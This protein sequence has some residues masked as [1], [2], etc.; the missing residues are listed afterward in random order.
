MSRKYSLCLAVALASVALDQITKYEIREHIR[1]Q[2]EEIPIF[3][4]GVVSASL[5]HAQNKGA[6]FGVLENQTAFFIGFTILAVGLLLYMLRELPSNDRFQATAIGLILSGALGNLIDRLLQGSV[7]DFIR[8]YTE[9]PSLRAW[10]ISHVQ[11][12]EWP[13]FNVADSAIVIGLALF[14]IHYLF[15]EKDSVS[16]RPE[17]PPE[18]LDETR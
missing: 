18:P 3:Q 10:L 17:P 4:T 5:V 2:V 9:Q 8:V 11:T 12:N 7:T 14:F 6:A 13:S 1:Y 16:A 15:F